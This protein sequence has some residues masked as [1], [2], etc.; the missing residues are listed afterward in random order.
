[1]RESTHSE[2][3]YAYTTLVHAV[4]EKIYRTARLVHKKQ[5][6]K[7]LCAPRRFSV[8]SLLCERAAIMRGAGETFIFFWRNARAL[9]QKEV[10]F[11]GQRPK[12][13]VFDVCLDKRFQA[14]AHYLLLRMDFPCKTS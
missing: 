12:K 7:E 10:L 8:S 2:C 5:G 3:V 9:G 11:K 14:D 13:Q 6:G 4:E 1:M